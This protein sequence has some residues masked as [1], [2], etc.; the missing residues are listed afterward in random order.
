LPARTP[1]G[2]S[3]FVRNASINAMSL[4]KL[5]WQ[6]FPQMELAN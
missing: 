1:S 5:A 2:Y 3:P 6:R 4:A